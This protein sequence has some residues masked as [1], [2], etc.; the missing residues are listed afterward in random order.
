[1]FRSVVFVVVTL[2]FFTG[3]RTTT[4]TVAATGEKLEVRGHELKGHYDPD[5]LD[6][7][8]DEGSTYMLESLSQGET[9]LDEL[10]FYNIAGEREKVDQIIDWRTKYNNML[11]VSWGLNAAAAVA[12]LAGA[13]L[14]VAASP[15]AVEELTDN[16]QTQLGLG[17][18]AGASIAFGIG[19]GFVPEIFGPKDR[20]HLEGDYE[21][22]HPVSDAME[23][24]DRYTGTPK[25]PTTPPP[26]P[27]TPPPPAT[28]A[29][30]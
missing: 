18:I 26:S 6:D 1:M 2:G 13:G 20:L 22:V 11:L 15:N 14:I 16:P 30:E 21:L 9:K 19:F 10:D 12:V 3:C 4:P 29:F 17:I 24:A 23:T 25:T 7:W 27:E 28:P 5:E 8:S